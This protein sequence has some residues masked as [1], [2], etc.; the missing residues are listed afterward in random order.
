MKLADHPF[1]ENFRAKVVEGDI[2]EA[3]YDLR[4]F[5]QANDLSSKDLRLTTDLLEFQTKQLTRDIR[6]G[7]LTTENARVER[8]RIAFACIDTVEDL[9]RKVRLRMPAVQ[10]EPTV[11]FAPEMPEMAFEKVLGIDS[12][13]KNISWLELGIERAKSVCRIATEN[14]YGSGFLGQDGWIY[15]NNHVLPD[16]ASCENCEVQFNYNLD[17]RGNPLKYFSYTLDGSTFFT[18]KE[19]DITRVKVKDDGEKPLA[20]WGFLEFCT[21][22]P[23]EGGHVTIIQHP[24]GARKQIALNE[25]K[26]LGFYDKYIHYSTDTLPGSSGSPVFDDEWKVVGVHHAGGNVKM[27][28]AGD[29]R[30]A[31]EAVL[32]APILA[33]LGIS[34]A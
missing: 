24:D 3:L 23:K 20:D 25:N 14:T 22:P 5:A 19:L 32:A 2:Q 6:I 33:I 34:P 1:F 12:N 7:I 21:E 11:A 8:A 15:T 26:V 4:M 10:P 16:A 18:S 29:K 9:Q 17:I 27:N 30:Y 28:D 13:L 31:N